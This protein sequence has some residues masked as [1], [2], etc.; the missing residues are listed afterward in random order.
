MKQ[1]DV[2]EIIKIDKALFGFRPYKRITFWKG[3]HLTASPT[4]EKGIAAC[5]CAI[6]CQRAQYISTAVFVLTYVRTV[7]IFIFIFFQCRRL[8]KMKLSDSWGFF[9]VRFF[10][11]SLAESS[12]YPCFRQ[13]LYLILNLEITSVSWEPTP[14]PLKSPKGSQLSFE[15]LPRKQ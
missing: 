1:V 11:F 15:N 8:G 14:R 9:A 4:I 6:E 10:K 12:A 2:V 3:A 7:F 13:A 5:K